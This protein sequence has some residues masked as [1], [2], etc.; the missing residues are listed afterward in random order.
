VEV[1]ISTT[2][3]QRSSRSRFS[4][5]HIAKGRCGALNVVEVLVELDRLIV[6]LRAKLVTLA[7]IDEG[8]NRAL[9]CAAHRSRR[10]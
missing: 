7:R 6:V 2:F 8:R 1:T 10:G 9:G 4:N 3:G 5:N